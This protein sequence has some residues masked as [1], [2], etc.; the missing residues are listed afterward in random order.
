MVAETSMAAAPPSFF[1]ALFFAISEARSLLH[2]RFVWRRA[3]TRTQRP[4]PYISGTFLTYINVIRR[5]WG[6]L[7][8]KVMFG[9]NMG[10][11]GSNSSRYARG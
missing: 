9:S 1:L 11:Y 10:Y 8:Q 4:K 2:K 6:T 5:V 7:H 3:H